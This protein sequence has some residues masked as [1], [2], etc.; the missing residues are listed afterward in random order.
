MEVGLHNLA[1]QLLKKGHEPVV[2]TSYSI[3]KKLKKNKI[4]LGYEGKKFS[5]IHFFIISNYQVH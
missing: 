4:N 2:I 1:T 5:T 3:F